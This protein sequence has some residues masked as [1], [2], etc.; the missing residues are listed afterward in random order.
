MCNPR[1]VQIRLTEDI[2]EAWEHECSRRVSFQGEVEGEARLQHDLGRTLS[3][4][5]L[6]ALVR[7]F[8]QPGSPWRRTDREWRVDLEG[9]HAL[10]REE[11]HVL[12]IVATR[13]EIVDVT[14]EA[15]RVLSGETAGTLTTEQGA[16]YWDDGY[17]GRDEAWANSEAE[18]AG[19][20]DIDAQRQAKLATDADAAEQQVSGELEREA[21][22]DGQRRFEAESTARRQQLAREAAA[23]LEPMYARTMSALGPFLAQA[24]RDEMLAYAHDNGGRDISCTEQNGVIDISFSLSR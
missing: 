5:V 15:R 21:S 22:L 3:S 2:R 23:G 12:E 10:F 20:R 24:Y 11:D 1:R 13:R 19:R 9:G 16:D 6:A 17:A 14:G 4:G 18:A 7:A 8:G